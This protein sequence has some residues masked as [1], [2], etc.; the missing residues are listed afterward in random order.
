VQFDKTL[1]QAQQSAAVDAA[2]QPLRDLTTSVPGSKVTLGGSSLIDREITKQVAQDTRLGEFVA[3]PVTLVVMVAIF[4]GF[5]AASIPLIGAVAAVAGALLVLLGFSHVMTLDSQVV[6]VT[7][8]LGLGLSIDYALLMVS[9]FREER[10][11]GHDDADGVERTVATAGRTVAF[12]ALTVAT[13]L[14]GLLIFDSPLFRAIGA[15]GVSIVLVA[16]LAALT[17][18][19]ALL[20]VFAHRVKVPK[21][22]VS[23]N[24]LFARSARLV[25]KHAIP[26]TLAVSALLIAAGA[27]MLGAKYENGG[28]NL[29]PKS[30]ASRQLADTVEQRFPVGGVEPVTVVSNAPVNQMQA[31]A[32]TLRGLHGVQSVGPAVAEGSGVTSVAVIPSGT[33]QDDVAQNVVQQIRDHRPGFETWVSGSAATVVDFQHDISSRAPWAL[34]LVCIATFVLLFLMTGSVLVP[35]KALLMNVVSLG[36][37]FGA[38][39]LVFQHGYFSGLLGFTPTGALE[40]WIPVIVFAFAFGLSMDYEVFLLAR[41]KELYDK[42]HSNDKAVELGVQRS[43]RI[44]T[45]AALLI[46]I[47]FLGFG[48]GKMLGIK[49]M[50][51]ALALAV[52]VDATLVRGLLVPATMTLLGDLNWWAP[53]PLRRLHNRI[54]LREVEDD[55]YDN[56]G[57]A[58]EAL[59]PVPVQW[60]PPSGPVRVGGRS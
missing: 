21:K 19:P 22:P 8:V 44:I 29:L 28:V 34:L 23:D 18:V 49:E 54:G 25:Q 32:D 31:Y 46:V 30:F 51:L 38:L 10:A 12:S 3:L 15:A 45:S 13:S 35:L 16:V 58:S 36:A 55:L 5:L 40:M 24:G 4:G 9:R 33:A 6:P 43:G 17:L 14:S 41:I 26:V 47:V 1:T 20:G 60:V 56:E 53:G 2:S 57:D 42:G 27:P 11:H 50:G 59:P 37:A 7:T 52:V 39:V 48:M